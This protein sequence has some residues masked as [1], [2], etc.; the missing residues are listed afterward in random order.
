MRKQLIAGVIGT[1]MTL[2][3][4]VA[5]AE[6]HAPPPRPIMKQQ[7]EK[8]RQIEQRIDRQ[9]HQIRS[10]MREGRLLRRE[11]A[12]L[13]DNLGGIKRAYR[14]ANRDRRIDR[15]EWRKLDFLLERNGR[16]IRCL[17]DGPPVGHYR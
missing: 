2:S 1:V 17:K 15:A 16:L 6:H 14:G 10:S 4:G 8:Q 11:A 12:F 7:Y 5:M 3:A 13:K 9:E